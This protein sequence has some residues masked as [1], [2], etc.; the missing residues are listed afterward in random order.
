[1]WLH[2]KSSKA[3]LLQTASWLAG[4]THLLSVSGTH[5]SLPCEHCSVTFFRKTA[6]F[7]IGGSQERVQ[8]LWVKAAKAK[9]LHYRMMTCTACICRGCLTCP[10]PVYMRVSHIAI[11]TVLDLTMTHVLAWWHAAKYPKPPFATVTL[12]KW[13]VHTKIFLTNG[14]Q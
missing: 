8:S 6:G 13:I 2:I 14:G 3:L 10:T 9:C 5:T 7:S 12:W 11:F 1:M 4:I